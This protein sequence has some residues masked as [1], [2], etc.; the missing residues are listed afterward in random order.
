MAMPSSRRVFVKLRQRGYLWTAESVWRQRVGEVAIAGDV[1]QYR[2]M[3]DDLVVVPD[4]ALVSLGFGDCR[5]RFA[6]PPC[7][8]EVLNRIFL[9][10]ISLAIVDSP[11]QP[12]VPY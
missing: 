6:V 5:C 1:W 7:W 9:Y 12:V 3:A 10:S 11:K 2:C 8:L 4:I